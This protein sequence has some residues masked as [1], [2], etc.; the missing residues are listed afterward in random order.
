MDTGLSQASRTNSTDLSIE[1]T[2]KKWV[3][4][5]N[6]R[7]AG[8]CLPEAEPSAR[9]Q[10]VIDTEKGCIA[11]GDSCTRYIALSYRW[12]ASGAF[13]L[14]SENMA[15]AQR[16][17][18][19][20]LLPDLAFPR[21][22]IEA[23]DL[24]QALDER[25]L[26]VDRLC[27]VQGYTN[28]GD[29]DIYITDDIFAGAYLT[30]VA[31]GS[32]CKA[33]LL[34]CRCSLGNF[35]NRK[36]Q[37]G[38]RQP[39]GT[40]ETLTVTQRP[41][42]L[43]TDYCRKDWTLG[44]ERD[45]WPRDRKPRPQ[46][47]EPKDVV[48]E[49]YTRLF[50][51]DWA[52]CGWTFQE[53]ML[54]RRCV[55]FLNDQLFWDCQ[56][57]V[58]DP[59]RLTPE[60]DTS[61]VGNMNFAETATRMAT[62]MIPDFPLYLELVCLYNN[63]NL[64][65]TGDG[66]RAMTGVLQHFCHNYPGGL[67]SGLPRLFLDSSLL[68]QPVT[69]ADRRPGQGNFWLPSWAWCGWNCTVEPRSL[70]PGLE[71]YQGPFGDS[72]RVRNLVQW[73]VISGDGAEEVIEEPK[74]LDEYKV[75]SLREYHDTITHIKDGW[76]RVAKGVESQ[77]S[78][79]VTSSD[80]PGYRYTVDGTQHRDPDA[81]NLQPASTFTHP[82]DPARRHFRNPLPIH[83]L[84]ARNTTQ[85]LWPHLACV[86][87][88]A[89]F[90]INAIYTPSWYDGLS[91]NHEL[92]K[93][94]AFDLPTMGAG[95]TKDGM[96]RVAS[97]AT[98]SG[99]FAGFIRLMRVEANI[100]IG[101]ST[102]LVALSTGSVIPMN[103]YD[104]CEESIL[105]QGDCSFTGSS[106]VYYYSRRSAEGTILAEESWYEKYEAFTKEAEKARSGA[107]RKAKNDGDGS[108]G[109]TGGDSKTDHNSPFDDV[110]IDMDE[111]FWQEHWDKRASMTEAWSQTPEAA[112]YQA[113]KDKEKSPTDYE[114]Y[115]VLW[116]DGGK[117]DR[118]VYRRGVG[119]VIKKV[120]EE[121][122]NEP[123]RIVLA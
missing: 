113:F 99:E 123:S 61:L 50:S 75:L 41:R 76:I 111:A 31:A 20:D 13:F 17:G 3:A 43:H 104:Q 52:R 1:E 27:V 120:W 103:I 66:P 109:D 29:S 74:T 11:P 116:V 47:F 107:P 64:T 63:R 14:N 84:P 39:A 49:H 117:D 105:G 90:K 59:I 106:K 67:V 95:I 16:P 15:D 38:T 97:L 5:C 81:N 37:E 68:W 65:Y 70:I 122:C 115:N 92:V 98:P 24:V 40:D 44:K 7:H 114:F 48:K 57:A 12:T 2:I 4:A 30:I 28:D 88:S 55:I 25:Y 73:S 101:V 110:D 79:S 53:K 42:F 22:V 77:L 96:C 100:D 9:P 71:G 89:T 62:N 119:R 86:T 112:F 56:C 21:V 18:F 35:P 45:A 91:H 51:S 69:N 121:N 80:F 102:E 72:Y 6:D 34:P 82:L 87:S 118:K 33:A 36:A 19:L 85:N 32:T 26:W 94:S 58:W 10:W 54:S 108:D 93:T 46:D 83:K 8:R 78:G 23:M 60:V